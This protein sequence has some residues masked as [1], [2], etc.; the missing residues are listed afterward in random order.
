MVES[1]KEEVSEFGREG[2]FSFKPLTE[3]E[4][5]EQ[6][7][8]KREIKDS[9]RAASDKAIACLTSDSFREFKEEYEKGIEKLLDIAIRLS[10]ENPYHYAFV[11]HRIMADINAIK[12]LL[13]GVKAVAQ[14]GQR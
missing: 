12:R 3:K 5:S 6:E 9:L 1:L 13:D 7:R 4:K 14:R 8:E 2:G 11:M 10:I